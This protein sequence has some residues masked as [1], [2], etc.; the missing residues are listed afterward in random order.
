MKSI[1]WALLLASIGTSITSGCI[2]I[3]D[4]DDAPPPDIIIDDPEGFFDV[5]W[6]LTEG[7]NDVPTNCDEGVTAEIISEEVSS[8]ERYVDVFT[9]SASAGITS[10]LP[11]AN[12]DVWVNVY[13]STDILIAQSSVI[14]TSI[15]F[16]NETVELDFS[17]PT[18]GY[19]ALDWSIEDDFSFLECG[20]VSADGVSLISTLASTDFAVDDIFSCNDYTAE[21]GKLLL[22][23]YVIVVSLLD[24]ETNLGNS[25]PRNGSLTVGNE[26]VDL[27]TFEFVVTP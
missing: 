11:A 5:T 7:P 4:D 19:F 27:G 9:C 23:D 24:G 2:I 17:F 14:R 10:S 26:Q 15:D 16:N 20:D 8:R 13:D 25:L 12:Y 21:T 6:T 18:G 1:A 3:E 22:G